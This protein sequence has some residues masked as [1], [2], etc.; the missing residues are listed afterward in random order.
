V[1]Y[2]FLVDTYE[3]EI[4]KVLIVWSM[5]DDRDLTQVSY[6]DG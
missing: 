4:L 5:F 6:H 1:A 3:T 2:Q